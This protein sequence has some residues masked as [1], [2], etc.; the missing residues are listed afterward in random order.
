MALINA[1]L[2]YKGILKRIRR[3]KMA[4]DIHPNAAKVIAAAKKYADEKYTES[5][6]NDT[7]FGKRY[8]MNNQ[9]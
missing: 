8:G 4:N 9:L 6:N 5:T 2:G 7:I 1:I 3:N